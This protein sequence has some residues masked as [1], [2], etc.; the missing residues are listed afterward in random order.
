MA[1]VPQSL[2][3]SVQK[4]SH[5][6]PPARLLI[7]GIDYKPADG[8]LVDSRAFLARGHNDVAEARLASIKRNG[9]IEPVIVVMRKILPGEGLTEAGKACE[10]KQAPVVDDGRQRVLDARATA[11]ELVPFI[12]SNVDDKSAERLALEL[13][14]LRTVDGPLVEAQKLHRATTELGL[15]MDEACESM[16]FSKATGKNRLALLTLSSEVQDFVRDGKLSPIAAAAIAKLPVGKQDE[17][18]RKLVEAKES[19]Q[20][21]T[22]AANVVKRKAKGDEEISIKPTKG[23]VKAVLKTDAAE[24]LGD[25]VIRVMKWMIGEGSQTKITGLSACLNEIEKKR[26]ARAAKKAERTVAHHAGAKK[27]RATKQNKKKIP[28]NRPK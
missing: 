10:G 13:N 14:A 6:L 25:D 8:F 16:G 9:V 1:R 4:M 24:A 23:L 18:A 3:G 2:E 26:E 19:G 15:T 5:S 7:A 17:E 27:P 20:G 12:V 21:Q 28:T 22:Q 11:T